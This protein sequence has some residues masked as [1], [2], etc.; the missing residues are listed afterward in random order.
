MDIQVYRPLKHS[1][2]FR[3][4]R[5]HLQCLAEMQTRLND[6]PH[7]AFSGQYLSFLHLAMERHKGRPKSKIKN[8]FVGLFL[9]N[10]LQM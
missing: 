8:K 10:Y 9:E 1:Y 4:L 2:Y 6:V 7:I 5:T 3:A